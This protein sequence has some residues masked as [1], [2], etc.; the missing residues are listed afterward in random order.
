MCHALQALVRQVGLSMSILNAK[1]TEEAEEALRAVAEDFISSAGWLSW[2]KPM[3]HLCCAR[4]VARVPV[5]G[6]FN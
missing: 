2:S 1:A 6:C 4:F 5:G 3:L